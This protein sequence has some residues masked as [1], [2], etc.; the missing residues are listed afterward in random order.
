MT[1]DDCS[2]VMY[3]TFPGSS[4][5]MLVPVHPHSYAPLFRMFSAR[6][7]SKQDERLFGPLVG[8][9][10]LWKS[11]LNLF[12]SIQ[13]FLGQTHHCDSSLGLDLD[14][15]LFSHEIPTTSAADALWKRS[16]R[17]ACFGPCTRLSATPGSCRTQQSA[18]NGSSE[19]LCLGFGCK[20][21]GIKVFEERS[22]PKQTGA[23]SDATNQLAPISATASECCIATTPQ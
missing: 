4:D 11:S 7:R 19:K 16:K 15:L 2:K 22:S 23:T 8:V 13:G 14:K 17:C 20:Q 3:F 9:G 6:S 12:H 5:L 10:A 1:D 18:R 21:F